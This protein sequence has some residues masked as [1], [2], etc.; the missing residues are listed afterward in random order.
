MTAAR[1]TGCP[2][3]GSPWEALGPD[4]GRCPRHGIVGRAEI[5]AARTSAAT[6]QETP[7]PA[8]APPAQEPAAPPR[9]PEASVQAEPRTLADVLETFGRWLHL[10]DLDPIL[11]T[12]GT[13]AANLLSGDP[14]W[15]LLVGAPGSGKTEMLQ[16]TRAAP[17]TFPAAT[18]TEAALL[19]GTASRERAAD[20]KGGLLR[21]VGDFGIIVCKDFGSILAMHRDTRA[22]VLAALREIYDGEWVRHV[23]VDGGRTLAWRGKVGLMAACT[24]IIDA[25]HSVIAAM[26]ERFLMIRLPAAEEDA[27]ADRALG[28]IGHEREMRAELQAAVAGLF[29]RPLGTPPPL[30]EDDRAYLINLAALVVRCRSGVERDPYRREI[31]L[32]PDPEAP[33]R[34]VTVLARL[35]AGLLSIGLSP[36][37]ARRVVTR[38]GMDSMPALRRRML[39]TLAAL[40]EPLDTTALARLT[41]YP[42]TTARRVLEDLTAHGAATCE[43]RGAGKADIWDLAAWTRR[44]YGRVTLPEKS[45][46]MDRPHDPLFH[47]PIPTPTDIS[48][49]PQAE[50]CR[51]CGAPV[52]YYDGGNEPWCEEH[53]PRGARSEAG[54][55]DTS[56]DTPDMSEQEGRGADD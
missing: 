8:S 18:L 11:A 40:A 25:H 33:A 16:S 35:L 31:T 39:D 45:P 46:P 28:H 2:R 4:G 53:G 56:P 37:E 52:A 19:S 3:C 51:E 36:G 17:H 29:A 7:A 22:A 55:P 38:V 6:A 50:R 23:G 14:V 9:K 1:S 10:P 21:V 30:T 20:A 12:L 49:K 41:G 47:T 15:L 34:L 27:Q 5:E 32:I 13:V 42:T 54:E 24:P 44:R 26:G 43:S 48:G